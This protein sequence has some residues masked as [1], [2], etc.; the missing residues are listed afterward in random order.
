MC[1]SA[2]LKSFWVQSA[3]NRGHVLALCLLVPCTDAHSDL[4]SRVDQL[5]SPSDGFPIPP[6]ATRHG[7]AAARKIQ[8]YPPPQELHKLRS[9][10]YTEPDLDVQLLEL[11]I[12]C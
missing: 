10:K 11:R 5:A 6:L 12:W 1:S 7:A 4:P 2:H 3:E 8:S 9:P